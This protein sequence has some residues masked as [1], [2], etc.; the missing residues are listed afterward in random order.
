MG[1]EGDLA[2]AHI[3]NGV[4]LARRDLNSKTNLLRRIASFVRAV[5]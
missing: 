1:F 4:V 2:G 5:R 3:R